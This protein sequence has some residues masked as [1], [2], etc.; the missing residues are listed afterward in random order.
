MR[1]QSLFRGPRVV[2]TSDIADVVAELSN[3]TRKY[4]VN[5]QRTGGKID[6]WL[7]ITA[8][9][10]REAEWIAHE[11]RVSVRTACDFGMRDSA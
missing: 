1:F 3:S 2:P 4:A 5:I 11:L 6:P 7:M 10:K 9:D 8:A